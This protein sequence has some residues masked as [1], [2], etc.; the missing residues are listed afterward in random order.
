MAVPFMPFPPSGSALVNGIVTEYFLPEITAAA[1]VEWA[2]DKM[3]KAFTHD[4]SISVRIK[5]PHANTRKFDYTD[6]YQD[7][8]DVKFLFESTATGLAVTF[9]ND[10]PLSGCME[11]SEQNCDG[12]LYVCA[13]NP[14]VGHNWV[15]VSYLDKKAVATSSKQEFDKMAKSG[16]FG[17]V[18]GFVAV[19]TEW[20]AYDNPSSIQ[21]E[22]FNG[23]TGCSAVS[24]AGYDNESY[25][26]LQAASGSCPP[27]LTTVTCATVPIGYCMTGCDPNL[28]QPGDGVH[29]RNKCRCN[30]DGTDCKDDTDPHGHFPAS[31]CSCATVPYGKCMTGCDPNLF[32]PG[33]GIN[34]HN[35]CD[36]NYKGTDCTGNYQCPVLQT[37]S[38]ASVVV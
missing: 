17:Y 27:P 10:G 30:F 35:K 19:S 5:M 18:D 37:I 11:F 33:D 6:F 21:F 28:F 34:S 26:E 14:L 12:M 38:N 31:G 8:N 13:S 16:V 32:Q 23:I 4:R 20:C 29:S 24:A 25:S 36:C 15:G 9:H 2:G 1:A 3:Q 7:H 22:L